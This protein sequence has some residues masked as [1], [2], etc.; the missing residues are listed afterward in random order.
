MIGEPP[1]LA[2]VVGEFEIDRFV[3]SLNLPILRACVFLLLPMCES[4][5][6]RPGSR[7]RAVRLQ[8]RRQAC[9]AGNRPRAQSVLLP[10]WLLQIA[11]RCQVR[12]RSGERRFVTTGGIDM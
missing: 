4:Q 7:W 8:Q 11:T 12:C 2:L 9:S 1:S 10:R 6:P 5:A 3:H